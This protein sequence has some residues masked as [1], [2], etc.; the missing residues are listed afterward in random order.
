MPCTLSDL[1]PVTTGEEEKYQFIGECYVDEMMDG[2]T[3]ELA[4]G[5]GIDAGILKLV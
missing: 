4:D 1:S 2:Q 5:R 3:V